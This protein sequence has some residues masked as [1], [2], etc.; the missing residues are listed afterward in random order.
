MGADGRV[1]CGLK[2]ELLLL[3]LTLLT[4]LDKGRTRDSRTNPRAP[5]RTK[6]ARLANAIS[7]NR[8]KGGGDGCADVIS[9][10]F[11]SLRVSGE[12]VGSVC[13]RLKLGDP[14]ARS[15]T[16]AKDTR[17]RPGEGSLETGKYPPTAG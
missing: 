8:S 16:D 14:R 6:E 1:N 4:L 2:A 13:D 10:F 3:L 7:N 12:E 11:L 15:W 17:I 5:N 9:L